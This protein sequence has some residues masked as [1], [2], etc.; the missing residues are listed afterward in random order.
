MWRLR[1]EIGRQVRAFANAHGV[2]IGER[3]LD[4]GFDADGDASLERRIGF[5]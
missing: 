4:S 3:L 2:Q 1:I 5:D